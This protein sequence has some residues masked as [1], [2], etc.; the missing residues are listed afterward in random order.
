VKDFLTKGAAFE[1]LCQNLANFVRPAWKKQLENFFRS[2]SKQ[3]Q[4]YGIDKKNLERL[5]G[6]VADITDVNVHSIVIHTQ[7]Q[8]S[9]VE[10]LQRRVEKQTRTEWDWWPLTRPRHQFHRHSRYIQFKCV[11]KGFLSRSNATNVET[12]LR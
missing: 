7:L 10:R 12:E 5:K 9:W 2:V 4:M 3:R 6:V 11:S 1:K 8:Q